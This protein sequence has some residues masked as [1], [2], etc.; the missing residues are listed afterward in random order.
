MAKLS[1]LIVGGGF[2][3]TADGETVHI[4]DQSK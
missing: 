2:S 1:E 3:F 4:T